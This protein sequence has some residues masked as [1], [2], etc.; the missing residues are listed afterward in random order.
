MDD[1]PS[2]I[3]EA[4]ATEAETEAVE[5]AAEAETEQVETVTEA[6]VEI[7]QIEADRDVTIEAIR[8]DARTAEAEAY[9]EARASEDND[10][11]RR[12]I[13]ANLAETN[14]RLAELA[15][16][17][18]P[19]LST[20]PEPSPPMNNPESAEEGPPAVEV[21]VEV[22]AA[23]PAPEPPKRARKSRWI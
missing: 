7:A 17:L 15:A 21:E 10:E 16:L 12:N 9:A 6:A 4:P 20:Q 5:I 3:V 8:A 23:Q 11:W 19:P 14:S 18:T 2:V 1:E 22:E 13:E